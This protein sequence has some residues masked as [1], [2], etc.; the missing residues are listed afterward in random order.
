MEKRKNK[1]NVLAARTKIKYD[2]K[3]LKHNYNANKK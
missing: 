1:I 2:F 3:L